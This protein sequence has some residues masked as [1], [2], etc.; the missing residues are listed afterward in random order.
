MFVNT[1]PPAA[2]KSEKATFTRKVTV[3]TINLVLIEKGSLV[4]YACQI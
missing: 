3:K 4:E 1:M 2:E